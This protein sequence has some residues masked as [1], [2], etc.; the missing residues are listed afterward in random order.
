L[1]LFIVIRFSLIYLLIFIY[2]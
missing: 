1:P 2:I